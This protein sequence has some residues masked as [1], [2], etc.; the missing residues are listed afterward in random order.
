[1]LAGGTS[2]IRAFADFGGTS[3]LLFE[4][5]AMHSAAARGGP[6]DRGLA[7]VLT[8]MTGAALAIAEACGSD[9]AHPAPTTE[10][11]NAPGTGGSPGGGGGAT[12]IGGT[13]DS[14]R[15]DASTTGDATIAD[16]SA[17]DGNAL[18]DA[19]LGLVDF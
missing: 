11:G 16:A 6:L 10:L 18:M 12:P 1:M 7:V 9:D 3:R 2:P 14:G 19:A 5:H 17:D 13:E 4:A 8:M 15:S